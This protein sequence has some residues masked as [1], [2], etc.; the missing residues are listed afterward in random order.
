[1]KNILFVI[2]TANQCNYTKQ[3]IESL[4]SANVSLMDVL[5][6]DDA[7]EDDT[8]KYCKSKN[9]KFIAKEKPLG[10]THS[11][12]LAYKYF[13]EH[14]YDYLFLSNND[15]LIPRGAIEQMVTALAKGFLIVGPLSNSK[16][17]PFNP[18]QDVSSKVA[19]TFDDNDPENYVKIQQMLD[20]IQPEYDYT[21][22]LNG[23]IFG[24]SRKIIQYEFSTDILFNPKNINIANEDELCERIE[25]TSLKAICNR[26]FIFHYK[27]VS[28]RSFNNG[29][30]Y[31]LERNLT[32]KEVEALKENPIRFQVYRFWRKIRETFKLT[33]KS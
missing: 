10:L 13:K 28:F 3:C 21:A 25:D 22:L 31:K 29:D 17:V 30:I 27:G 18:S 2:T 4:F 23:Y 32:W 33:P 9:I 14:H 15:I 24:L 20:V 26:S 8:I 5:I 12:N 11:W 6:I 1:M 16:G 19:L 7:S